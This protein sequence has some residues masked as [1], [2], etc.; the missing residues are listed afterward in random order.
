MKKS[1]FKNLIKEA[2]REELQSTFKSLLKETLINVFAE[3]APAPA[4]KKP[5][6]TEAFD[7]GL[8]EEWP[9]LGR[10]TLTTENTPPSRANIAAMLGYGEAE[11]TISTIITDSGVERPIDPAMIPPD[12]KEALNKDYRS[13]MK[14]LDAKIAETRGRVG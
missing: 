10:K 6:L 4:K 13:L 11:N 5:S 3:A 1:E 8:E 14:K 9:T 7:I 12:V 2:I